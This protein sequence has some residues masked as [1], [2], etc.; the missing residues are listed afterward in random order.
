MC[1]R[2]ADLVVTPRSLAFELFEDSYEQGGIW[3]AALGLATGALV[4][5]FISQRLDRMAEGNREKDHGSEKLDVDAAAADEAA[6]S[7]SVSGT[8]GLLSGVS[9][10]APT[11]GVT[12]GSLTP[13]ELLAQ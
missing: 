13:G 4:F 9:L 6:S 11:A 2:V 10:A 3:R 5:T 8:A 12:A 1:A 7:A